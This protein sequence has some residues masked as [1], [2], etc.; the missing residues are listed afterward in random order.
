MQ[1]HLP[2]VERRSISNR[3]VHNDDGIKRQVSVIID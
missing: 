2:F 3:Y 1:L